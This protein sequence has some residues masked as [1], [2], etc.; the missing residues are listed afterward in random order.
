MDCDYDA[1]STQKQL[2]ENS[3]R[4]KKRGR[5]SK[6]AQLISEPK[7]VF[8]PNDKTYEEYLDEYY[9]FDCEDIIGDIPCRFKYRKV[10]PNSFG[11][12]VEEVNIFLMN[13]C[14]Q[15]LFLFL[16][17]FVLFRFCWQ[18]IAN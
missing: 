8:D 2:I 9:K 14:F 4:K 7:P 6:F 1:M 12:S 11:L 17:A 13:V 18:K 10:V 15:L 16:I 5:K 3:K